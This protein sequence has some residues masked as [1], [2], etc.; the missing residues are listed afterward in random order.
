M[1]PRKSHARAFNNHKACHMKILIV[2]DAWHPQVN[3]VVRTYENLVRELDMMGHD[4]RVIGPGDFPHTM[5]MPGYDEIH[6]TLLPW[7]ILRKKIMGFKPDLLHIGTEGPIGLAARRYAARYELPFTTCYHTQFPDYIAARAGRYLSALEKPVHDMAVR[8]LRW[9][10]KPSA[11]LFTATESL[12]SMLRGWGATCPIKRMTRGVDETV[13]HP[14]PKSMFNDLARPVALCVARLA[15]EKNLDA[16]LSMDWPGTK[17]M[18][19]DGPERMRLEK[20]YP[21][22]HFLGVKTG[23][24]LGDC[25]RSADVFVFPS[26]TDTFGMVMV[27]AMACG[28]PVAAYPVSGPADIIDRDFLGALDEDLSTAAQRATTCGTAEERANHARNHY[29]WRKAATQFL[30]WK[31]P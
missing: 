17:V 9:F 27:E 24:E 7:R 1:K 12:E 22:A 8:Y 13:F 20:T 21:D 30:D 31:T 25:Y 11:A 4:V 29:T 5:P 3:G 16:F 28:L 18:V 2:T 14:G 6:L 26:K 15:V 19:G 10:H 23:S